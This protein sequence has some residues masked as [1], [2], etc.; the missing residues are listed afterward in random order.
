MNHK[1]QHPGND[2]INKGPGNGDNEF[3]PRLVRDATESRHTADR[4]QSNVRR[5]YTESPCRECVAELM[6]EYAGEQRQDKKHPLDSA[7]EPRHLIVAEPNPNEKY[8]EGQ[9]DSHFN[10]ENRS[11]FEG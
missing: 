3:L 11:D 9:V 10:P 8:Q 6:Q 7:S 1:D 5:L 2:H 4:Q